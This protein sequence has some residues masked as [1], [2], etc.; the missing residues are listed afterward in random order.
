M[1]QIAAPTPEAADALNLLA[2][3]QRLLLAAITRAEK[4]LAARKSPTADLSRP[5]GALHD[6]E[7]LSVQVDALERAAEILAPADLV[8][9]AREGDPSFVTSPER[10]TP[11]P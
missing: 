10:N 2:E 3:T 5:A 8:R 7:R 11:C 4:E 6:V 9:T 1:A